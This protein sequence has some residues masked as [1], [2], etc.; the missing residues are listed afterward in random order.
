MTCRCNLVTLSGE[1]EK[2]V[3]EDYSAGHIPTDQAREIIKDIAAQLKKDEAEFFAGVSYR[4]L[5]IIKN[6]KISVS[7]T[8]PHDILGKEI[9]GFLPKGEGADLLIK[10]MSDAKT[11]LKNH[12]VNKERAKNGQ[13]PASGIWL[14]G[15]GTPPAL[16]SF[17]KVY[18]VSGAVISA[19]DLVRGIGKCAAME[20]IDVPGAT[21][22]LDTNYEGK[23]EYALK[24]L[25]TKD[26]VMIHIEATDETGHTGKTHLKVRAVEDFDRRVAGPALRGMERFGNFKI[27]ITSDHPTSI[28]LRTH[29]RDPVPFAIYDSE[30]KTSNPGRTYSETCAMETGKMFERGWEIMKT[31]IT[32]GVSQP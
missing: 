25:E 20:V 13:P 7:S 8:P 32:P 26:L 17:E 14:W 19:V 27:L 21:G 10:I 24:S 15:E 3:M 6:R 5:L 18:G 11:I 31:F 23:V 30:N 22:Y 4:H 1:G 16:P 12:P 29:S 9:G 28:S 2:A